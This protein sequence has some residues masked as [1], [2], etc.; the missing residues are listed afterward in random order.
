QAELPSAVFAK[1]T[2]EEPYHRE[3]LALLHMGEN[4]VNFYT[5]LQPELPEIAPKAYY[6]RSYPGGRYL[7]LT[8][9]L[10]MR[11]LKPYWLA[12]KCSLDHAKAVASA[13]AQFHA[14]YW[15][16]ERFETDLVWVRPRS[17]RF[18]GEWHMD[19]MIHARSTFLQSEQGLALPEKA[20]SVLKKYNDNFSRVLD[21]WD[22]KPPTL[23]HGDSH[24]GNTFSYP[25]G[26]AGYFDWQLNIRGYG[27]RDLTFS[28]MSALDNA[29]RVAHEQEIFTHY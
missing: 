29:S 16:S 7:L 27:V 17:R 24:L 26:R 5:Q 10:K 25:D 8:E 23:L 20:R 9:A 1:A 14:R 2:P 4:E 11:Q 15:N 3:T 22:S 6:A 21:Y 19:S 12:D 13:Q 18:G 28:M